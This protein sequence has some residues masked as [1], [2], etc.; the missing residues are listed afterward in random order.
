MFHLL[1]VVA[2]FF[3]ENIQKFINHNTKL[4]H[5]TRSLLS[6]NSGYAI[7]DYGRGGRLTTQQPILINSKPELFIQIVSPTSQ[8]YSQIQEALFQERI[9]MFSLLA[10]TMAA[11]AAFIVFLF[12][13]SSTLEREAKRRAQELLES[14]RKARDLENSYDA[15]KQYL[16]EMLKEL[17]RKPHIQKTR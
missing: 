2:D 12:K 3:G 13:W 7:Y 9:K 10:G 11:I 6:G 15:M 1:Q 4:N 17:K 8:L 5:L 16:D 14:E